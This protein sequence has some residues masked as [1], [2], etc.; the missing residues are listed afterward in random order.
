MTTGA[1]NYEWPAWG[2]GASRPTLGGAF[3]RQTLAIVVIFVL[4]LASILLNIAATLV[5]GLAIDKAL[6]DSNLQLALRLCGVAGICYLVGGVLWVLQGRASTRLVYKTSHNIRSSASQLILNADLTDL[7]RFGN[8]ATHSLIVNDVENLGRAMQGSISQLSNSLL[9]TVGLTLVMIYISP[10]LAIVTIA[11]VLAGV[12]VSRR[13][14]NVARPHYAEEF[15]SVGSLNESILEW[16]SADRS[17]QEMMKRSGVRRRLDGLAGNAKRNSFR[18]QRIGG[19]AQPISV[20]IS[21]GGYVAVIVLGVVQLRNGAI[22]VGALQAMLLYSRQIS[23]P[24]AQLASLGNVIQAGLASWERLV[25]LDDLTGGKPLVGRTGVEQESDRVN[26]LELAG[27]SLSYG[28]SHALLP[29]Q[30]SFGCGDTVFLVGP[31]GSGKSTLAGL[32]VGLHR[33]DA[34]TVMIDGRPH[35]ELGPQVAY[36]PQDAFLAQATIVENIA[37]SWP[38]DDNG[39][40]GDGEQPDWKSIVDTAD[41]AGVRHLIATIDRDGFGPDMSHLGIAQRQAISI[42][43]VLQD[44]RPVAVLDEP[45]SAFDVETEARVFD[46]LRDKYRDGVLV[47]VAHRL[48]N[49]EPTDRVVRLVDGQIQFDELAQKAG[50]EAWWEQGYGDPDYV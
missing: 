43:R 44:P 45:T 49:I 27:V 25:A 13:I 37:S 28:D 9:L 10:T 15:S 1:V 32:V 7:N 47:I 38:I 26:S 5:V 48:T 12:L 30:A 8:T 29:V 14:T 35:G 40:R 2:L 46:A 22:T 20:A 23:G 31:T 11:T 6:E 36:I 17:T 50:G 24:L 34:G 16:L 39:Y 19:Q 41:R 21:Y 4:G 18:A 42:V 33:P 3:R